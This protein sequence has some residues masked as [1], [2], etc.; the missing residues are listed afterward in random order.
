S[1]SPTSFQTS[2]DR[3]VGRIDATGAAQDQPSAPKLLVKRGSFMGISRRAHGPPGLQTSLAASRVE[4]VLDK[5]AHDLLDRL[6]RREAQAARP[7]RIER[8]RPGAHDALDVRRRY[9]PHQ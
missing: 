9:P 1:S 2:S 6:V 8:G 4:V 5:G 3:R 7:D